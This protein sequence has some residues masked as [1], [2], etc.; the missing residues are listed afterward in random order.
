MAAAAAIVLR[1]ERDMVNQYRGA[2][3]L[4]AD[5]ARDPGEVGV[6]RGFIFDRLV[7]SAVLR[8]ASDGRYYLDE[9]SWVAMRRIRR[10][11]I[12]V[13]LLIVAAMGTGLFAITLR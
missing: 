3:A 2:G 9:P 10:R 11:M 8:E 1:R 4:S 13:V 12:V 5:A 7:S 6:E